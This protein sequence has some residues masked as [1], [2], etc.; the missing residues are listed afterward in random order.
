VEVTGTENNDRI[1]IEADPGDADEILVTVFNRVTGEILEQEDYDRE[2]VASIKVF[3][4]AGNDVVTNNTDIQSELN[5]EAGIDSL[6]GGAARDVIF[7]GTEADTLEGRGGNDDLF[8]GAGGDR[9]N[10]FGSLLGSDFVSEAANVDID[11]FDFS[12]LAGGVNLDLQSTATQTVN[13]T[14]LSL[15]LS[16]SSGI[17]DV[18]GSDF[19]DTLL[20][21]SRSNRLFGRGR[22]D[23]LNGRGGAD[24]LDGGTSIDIITTDA[25]DTVFGGTGR[26]FFDGVRENS[27]TPNP[28]PGRYRDWGLL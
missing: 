26:D 13:S 23:A 22:F 11:T 12:T 6:I 19:D 10:F 14:H 4:G 20:G 15:R 24:T 28:R 21:N 25:L 9:Y 2:D 16:S 17:E 3:A 5:G 7:G 8:G 18:F 1:V 27:N